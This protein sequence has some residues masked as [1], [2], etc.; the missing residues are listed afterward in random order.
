MCCLSSVSLFWQ[1]VSH[2]YYFQTSNPFRQSGVPYRHLS[3]AAPEHDASSD[4]NKHDEDQLLANY[5]PLQTCHI[6]HSCFYHL[7]SL[8]AL[9]VGLIDGQFFRVER[10]I[11]AIWVCRTSGLVNTYS[12]TKAL[13]TAPHG[14]TCHST[15]HI[16]WDRNHTFLV[17]PNELTEDTWDSLISQR[18]GF[19]KHPK[20]TSN[21]TKSV[22]VSH[23]LH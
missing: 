9:L 12:N 20:L 23:E 2:L 7:I 6:R 1:S 3:T 8:V 5:S 15:D 4:Q 13:F 10:D 21:E 14:H 22:S 19:V 18:Q 17:E 11:M 16:I